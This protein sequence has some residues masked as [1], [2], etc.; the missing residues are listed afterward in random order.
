[1][2]SAEAQAFCRSMKYRDSCTRALLLG[3]CS[4]RTA[5]ILSVVEWCGFRHNLTE[6]GAESPSDHLTCVWYEWDATVVLAPGPV[7]VQS[8]DREILPPALSVGA[9]LARPPDETPGAR[10]GRAS[11]RV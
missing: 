5:N 9:T 11:A 3:S 1:M 4:L 2:Q 6:E 8:F 10:W 7:L